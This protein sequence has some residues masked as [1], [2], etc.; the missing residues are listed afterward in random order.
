MLL[1]IPGKSVNHDYII[2]KVAG[3]TTQVLH[4][5]FII[6]PLD[7]V[8]VKTKKNKREGLN[9][10]E[11]QML[12]SHQLTLVCLS[13]C[14]LQGHHLSSLLVKYRVVKTVLEA[15]IC[16]CLKIVTVDLRFV[17]ESLISVFG[18]IFIKLFNQCAKSWDPCLEFKLSTICIKYDVDNQCREV[19]Q[20][21]QLQKK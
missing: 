5:T 14:C 4:V 13:K 21:F 16:K 11:K 10:R 1:Y 20:I 7:K 18:I 19:S 6:H 9:N 3:L 2:L 12:I 17:L 8:L 15:F